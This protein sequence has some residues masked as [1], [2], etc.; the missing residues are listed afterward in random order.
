LQINPTASKKFTRDNEMDARFDVGSK[1]YQPAL[2]SRS[3]SLGPQFRLESY[4]KILSSVTYPAVLPN[5]DLQYK[6][7]S[8]NVKE[9]SYFKRRFN[10][11]S[12]FVS[13][14]CKKFFDGINY[15]KI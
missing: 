9:K 10:Y 7:V 13:L 5:T 14:Q 1:N 12:I 4:Q 15:E 2:H 11:C 3:K 8:G 6:L